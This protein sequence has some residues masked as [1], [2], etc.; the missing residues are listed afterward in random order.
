MEMNQIQD[1]QQTKIYKKEALAEALKT[2]LNNKNKKSK[3]FAHVIDSI[4]FCL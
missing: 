1:I 4:S 2:H 3:L